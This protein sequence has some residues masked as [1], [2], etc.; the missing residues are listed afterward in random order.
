VRHSGGCGNLPA[1]DLLEVEKRFVERGRNSH[2]ASFS[3]EVVVMDK[4]LF[5]DL[6]DSLK[7]ASAIRAGKKSASRRITLITPH[8][9]KVR[10]QTGLTQAEFA[11][12]L[13]VSVKTLQN[14]EQE[15]RSPTGACCRAAQNRFCGA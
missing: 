8:V 13:Q 7:E 10:A 11:R 1:V 3:E 15:R 4:A 14:W 5:S 12:V 9:R 2:F 6:V